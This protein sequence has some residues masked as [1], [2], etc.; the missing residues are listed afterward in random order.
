MESSNEI[1]HTVSIYEGYAFPHT[2]L[3]LDLA[4]T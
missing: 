3:C 4:G 2:I 1:T